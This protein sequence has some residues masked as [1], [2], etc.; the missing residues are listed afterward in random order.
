MTA[1]FTTTSW[2]VV[3]AAGQGDGAAAQRAWERLAGVYWYPLYAFA[4]RSG[5]EPEEAKDQTQSFFAWLIEDRVVAKASEARGRFRSFLLVSFKRHL[6]MAHRRATALKRGGGV[7]LLSLDT[8]EAEE[9]YGREPSDPRTPEQLFERRWA[10]LIL[11]RSLQRLEQEV[12]AR[13]GAAAWE[14]LRPC[15]EGE[16]AQE[17]YAG[18]ALRL[19][20]S[21]TA[22]RSL[23]PR[24]RR[25]LGELVRAELAELVKNAAELEE[26]MRYWGSV[27]RRC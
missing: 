17:G 20:Q 18:I 7:A 24:L 27:L 3:V 19:G 10:L 8:I 25:R 26:E 15:I 23:V 13:H 2:S 12:V 16:L 22:V 6:L 14:Q 5:S 11:E 1:E 4:R 9:C 21:E